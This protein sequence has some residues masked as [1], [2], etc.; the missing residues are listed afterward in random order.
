MEKTEPEIK[1]ISSSIFT[2]VTIK[3]G[4]DILY[5]SKDP[6]NLEAAINRYYYNI[7]F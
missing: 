5:E 3:M 4:Q 6:D 2:A 7:T 1:Q